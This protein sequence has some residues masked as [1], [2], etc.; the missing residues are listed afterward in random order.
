MSSLTRRHSGGFTLAEAMLAGAVLA[1]AG[2]VLGLIVTRSMRSLTRA[3]DTQQ[4]AELLDRTLTRIDLIGPARLVAEGPTEGVFLPPHDRFAWRA[5]I[6]PRL[7]GNL[8]EVTV[9]VAWHTPGGQRRSARLQ[10]LLNDPPGA[11]PEELQWGDL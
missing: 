10:T 9:H 2:F 1:M 4:A 8:Y 7:E 6:A 5:E 3:R 11:R